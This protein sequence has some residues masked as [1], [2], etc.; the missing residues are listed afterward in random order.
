[1]GI[2]LWLIG[3]V[4]AVVVGLAIFTS[5]DVHAVT[6]QL[7]RLDPDGLAKAMF[8]A[9]GLVAISKFF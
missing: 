1:M 4:I 8:L 5:V 7:H 6:D 3:V 9:L 2:V